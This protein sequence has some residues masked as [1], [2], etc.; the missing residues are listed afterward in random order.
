MSTQAGV[1]S[2]TEWQDGGQKRHREGWAESWNASRPLHL[3]Q[4]NTWGK[5]TQTIAAATNCHP[6]SLQISKINSCCWG[7]SQQTALSCPLSEVISEEETPRPRSYPFPKK[8]TSND[9]LMWGY[10]GPVPSPQLEKIRRS[11]QVYR[12]FQVSRLVSWGLG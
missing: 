8:P 9:R 6:V 1:I 10:K 12:S 2:A 3:C 4:I 5:T 7:F 11:I